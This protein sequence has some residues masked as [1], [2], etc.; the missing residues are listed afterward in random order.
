[1]LSERYRSELKAIKESLLQKEAARNEEPQVKFSLE[2]SAF[3]GIRT[4]INVESKKEDPFHLALS[5]LI[6]LKG[7]TKD[8]DF[9]KKCGLTRQ[10]FSKIMG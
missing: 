9:Y 3:E 10:S 1:M 7:F 4:Y 5:R 2:P 8:S 6:L